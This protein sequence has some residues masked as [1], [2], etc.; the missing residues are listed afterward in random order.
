MQNAGRLA[1]RGAVMRFD[2][3]LVPLDVVRFNLVRRDRNLSQRRIRSGT[4]IA[5]TVIFPVDAR[6]FRMLSVALVQV[7]AAFRRMERKNMV[8]LGRNNRRK[9]YRVPRFFR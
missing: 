2:V 7:G 8:R 1:G 6:C 3:D 5:R 9:A 4:Y